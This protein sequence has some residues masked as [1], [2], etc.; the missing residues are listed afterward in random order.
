MR[1]INA[2]NSFVRVC[3]VHEAIAISSKATRISMS[4]NPSWSALIG[5]A[6]GIQ[7]RRHPSVGLNAVC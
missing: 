4:M 7:Q 6:T 5:G 3:F 1:F 2:L